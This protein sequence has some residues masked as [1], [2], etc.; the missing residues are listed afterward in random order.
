M[1]LSEDFVSN[2]CN[3]FKKAVES[4]SE[5][6]L[7]GREREFRRALTR[8]LIDDI[9]GWEDHSKIGEIYDI[10]CFDDEN[11][12]II[13]VETKWGVEP[14]SEIKEKLRNHIE[15]LGS[16]KYGV[17]ANEK[18]FLVYEYGRYELREVTKV[19]VA[20]AVGVAKK[21][22]GLSEPEQR[23]ILKIEML[24]RDHFVWLERPD[25]F[26]KTCKQISVAKTGGV[27][28]LTGNLKGII[29]DLTRVVV[30]FFDSYRER[31]NH[32]SNRFLENTFNDWL[33]ISTK[34]EDF[35][36]GE[37]T[38]RRSIIEVFSRETSYVILGRLLFTRI[39]EDKGIIDQIVSGKGIAESLRYY[40]KRATEKVY[41][42]LFN[43]SR[44]Q[45]RKYYRHLHELGFFDWWVIE[46]VKKDTLSYDDEK[47][48][49]SLETSLNDS[50]RKALR[51][52]N[53][54][55]FSKVTRDILG[56]VYQGYLPKD[57][58]K[59]L[60]EFY[61][62]KEVS[63]YIL[64]T[65]G[66]K[67]ENEI[68]GK[69][70]L[71][72]SCGSGSFLVESTQRLVARYR[73]IGLDIG[74]PDD[75]KQI[76]EQCVDSI[77]GLDIHPFACFIAEMNLLFQLV[78][79]YDVVRQKDRDYELPR[80]KIY[81]TDSLLPSGQ[82]IELAEFFENSR[83]KML[84]DET[85]GADRLKIVKFDFIVGNPPYVR[86]ERISTDYK[87]RKLRK[88]FPE[89]YY[90]DN[91]L[92]VYFIAKGIDWLSNSGKLGYIVSRK[93]TKTRYGANIRKYITDTCIVEEFVDFGDVEAFRDATNYPCILVLRKETDATERMK[94]SLK[95]VIIKK[96]KK[97][98]EL[99][100]HLSEKRNEGK[101]SDDYIDIFQVSQ[102]S[103]GA[104]RWKLVPSELYE[105]FNRIRK[106]S[107][108]SLGDICNIDK[109]IYTA[110]DKAFVVDEKTIEKYNLEKELLRPTLRG[111]DVKSYGIIPKKKLF[112]IYTLNIDINDY[113]NTKSYLSSF[114]SA[115]EKRW[116]FTDPH[117]G[118]KW[119]ELEKPRSPQLYETRK[120]V[121][122]DIS[123]TSN[124]AID[125]ENYYPLA[126]CFVINPKTDYRQFISYLLGVLNSKV[127]TF[128]FRQISTFIRGKY[129]R[130]IKQYLEQLPIRKC[131]DDN[132][133]IA[134]SIGQKVDQISEVSESIRF[135]K[136]RIRGFPESYFAGDWVF[137]KLV[138]LVKAQNLSDT[139]FTISEKSLRTDYIQRDLDGSE[140]FRI[141]LHT[142]EFIDFH[143]E[144]IATYVF[145]MLRR[146]ERITKRELLEFKILQ[147]PYLKTLLN[148]NKRDKE[149]S[150][151]G[152]KQF[153]DLS[154][155][156]DD[157]VYKLYDIS[158]AERRIVEGYLKKF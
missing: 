103:L 152:E 89:V 49:N 137:D 100:K 66:F 47:I 72:P 130:Y 70:I 128:Y 50:I 120:I 36:K 29:D 1:S 96:E 34:E 77:H 31:R 14:T 7:E 26:E 8:H 133:Q 4:A 43:E 107:E 23:R 62:P 53:R 91:D 5:V 141:I 146:K 147:K 116:C 119:Y 80:I 124:F 3:A 21:K 117:M 18:D 148:Q 56:D 63:E 76:I 65:L 67:P 22:Y 37:E 131:T 69:K 157:L 132:R 20:E 156:I 17:I 78:D 114:R 126:T 83:R 111:E 143:T 24:K 158:Y 32:Y 73:R 58:R 54:F 121:T 9:L 104:E 39:C 55:D 46:E 149:K 81:Q 134:E 45:V 140:T 38:T 13:I 15:E 59:R 87:E 98:Q 108:L 129:Y 30:N 101:F 86:K 42:R 6:T 71:D 88:A 92:Y 10:A 153:E 106:I 12:P 138:N 144:D 150:I 99:M 122:P 44:G 27:E 61:T 118:R 19:N 109:G 57:E 115:L 112:L 52:L 74:N 123:N 95:T 154:K 64:D 40:G 35:K 41:L 97:P 2:V 84:I 33:R 25:Y 79:L 127:M 155:Q 85:K 102:T 139:A 68:R 113:P 16:V 82:P 142:N 135:L 110:L 48:Q 60:G 105:M 28:L 75:A 136:E 11:F 93:F 51:R 125:N 90:G 151:T 145:E 94:S